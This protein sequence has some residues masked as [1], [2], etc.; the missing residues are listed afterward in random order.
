MHL[1]FPVPS[2][3]L[4]VGPSSSG[5]STWAS[6]SFRE[7]Q[8]LSTDHFRAIVGNS[9]RDQQASARAF[10][11]VEQLIGER[12]DTGLV[13]VVDSLGL[14]RDQRERHIAMARQRQ[15]PVFAVGFDT[16]A[17]LCRQRNDEQGRPVPVGVLNGQLKRW[18]IVRDTEL[19]EDGFDDV[20]VFPSPPQAH[21]VPKTL[22]EALIRAKE[23][24]TSPKQLA[25]GLVVSQFPWDTE[26][27]GPNVAAI[28]RR[29][30]EVGF[31]S[32]W[33]MDHLRQIPQLGAAWDALPE[34]Y[35]TLAFA[36]GVTERIRLGAMVTAITYRNVGLLG[37]M[38]ATLDL[39]SG[40][41]AIAGLGAGWFEA[42]ATGYGYEWLRDGRRLDVLEDA[43]QALPKVWGPGSKPF[44][45]KTFELPDTTCYPRPLQERIP[46]LVGGG[47]EK[48]TLRLVAQYA[49]ATNQMGSPEQVAHKLDVLRRHCA[50]VGRDPT[51]IEV[52][53]LASALAAPDPESLARR[54][55]S[56][57]TGGDPETF[58]ARSGA[59]TVEDQIGRFRTYADVGVHTMI[60]GIT[61]LETPD[62]LEP[63]R[64][65]IDAFA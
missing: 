39:L 56:L 41:R 27:I 38:I 46:M 65:I 37:K 52:T 43:L 23:Q 31:D 64:R 49:D 14:S 55:A 15:V 36:A 24:R 16:D 61:G 2:L 42:E 45:G 32:F 6:E 22:S 12:L 7:G 3:I 20:H 35:T 18:A 47:G 51:D 17:T 29:A 19:G 1:R 58:A 30:E 21:L 34:A 26:T 13:T 57:D 60:L 4:L 11:L 28:A 50:D 25:F 9:S 40:G 33:V 53:V 54:I 5:K 10:E 44:V 48:R 62:D 63:Y 59:G 8:V